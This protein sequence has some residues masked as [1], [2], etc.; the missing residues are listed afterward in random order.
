MAY[1]C[2]SGQCGACLG[3]VLSGEVCYSDGLPDAISESEASAGLAL[4]CSAFAASDLV[5]EL[6]RP[7]FGAPQDRA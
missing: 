4:F 6:I 7:D 2:R 5:I 1:S 3:R